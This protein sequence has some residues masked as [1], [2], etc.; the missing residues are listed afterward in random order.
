MKKKMFNPFDFKKNKEKFHK[1]QLQKQQNIEEESN[2]II[3]KEK[4]QQIKKQTDNENKIVAIEMI[5]KLKIS[6][7]DDVHDF[8]KEQHKKGRMFRLEI[9]DEKIYNESKNEKLFEHLFKD[10]QSK[11]D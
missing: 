3:E 2:K 7:L 5:G 4:Q 9:D 8:I 11:G 6:E 1:K 10:L